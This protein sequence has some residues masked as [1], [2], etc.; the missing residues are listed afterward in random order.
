MHNLTNA[1][2]GCGPAHGMSTVPANPSLPPTNQCNP[3]QQASVLQ[4]CCATTLNGG[5][6]RR[7]CY[8]PSPPP[9]ETAVRSKKNII[10]LLN[11]ILANV[12]VK[13][14]S[15]KKTSLPTKRIFCLKNLFFVDRLIQNSATQT[16]TRATKNWTSAPGHVP[17]AAKR[18]TNKTA[19]TTPSTKETTSTNSNLRERE[20]EER[21]TNDTWHTPAR[22]MVDTTHK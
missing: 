4:T 20:T 2:D 1:K 22:Q 5:G 18:N 12:F 14:I 3:T 6:G 19:S 7:R 15:K 21:E 8:A 11:Q 17:A 10:V 16:I 13:K 9:P